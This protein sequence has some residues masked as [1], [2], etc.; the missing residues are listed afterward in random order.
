MYFTIFIGEE[1]CA[2]G[3]VQCQKGCTYADIYCE[4]VDDEIIEYP[5]DFIG[6]I[7]IP[8]NT[9]QEQKRKP[10]TTNVDIK[11]KVGTLVVE[12]LQSH[13]MEG[14]PIFENIEGN[15]EE[16]MH[17]QPRVDHVSESVEQDVLVDP[18]VLEYWEH[19]VNSLMEEFVKEKL[20]L[21]VYSENG[22]PNI[23]IHYEMCGIDYGMREVSLEA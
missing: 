19:K 2:L 9:K 20:T 11:R 14:M 15:V 8:L 5:F 21:K 18:N 12:T 4:I 16:P 6:P 13:V 1:N 7:G 23:K 10:T 3:I 17:K 22:K